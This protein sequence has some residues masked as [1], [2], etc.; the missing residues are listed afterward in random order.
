[1]SLDGFSA[2]PEDAMDWVFEYVHPSADAVDVIGE[3][4]AV[5]SGRR[6]YDVG[7]RDA[8]KPSGEVYG[9]A[10]TGPQF[11]L[12]HAPPEDP[13]DPTMTFLSGSIESAVAVALTAAEGGGST[14]R[15][16]GSPI[17]TRWSPS[18]PRRQVATWPTTSPHRLGELW[19][20]WSA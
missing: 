13:R 6:S 17:R 18:L 7:E 16:S 3:I 8:G 14:W 12:T 4:G 1:M 2:G 9:G 10:W 19:W 20:R 15:R 5:L 11:V